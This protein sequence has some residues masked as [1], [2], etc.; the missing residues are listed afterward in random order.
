MVKEYII[1]GQANPAADTDTLLFEVPNAKQFVASTLAICNL[2]TSTA[3]TYRVAVVP[4]GETLSSKHYLRYD[5]E[6]A[7]ASDA[8]MTWGMSLPALAKVY[9]RAGSVDVAFTLFGAKF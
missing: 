7:A 9:V 4:S 3:T 2:S 1:A 5:K 8:N 6:L